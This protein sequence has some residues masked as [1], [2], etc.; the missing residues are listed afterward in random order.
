[1][2]ILSIQPMGT[3]PIDLFA[4]NVATKRP[5]QVDSKQE[6]ENR[7]QATSCALTRKPLENIFKKLGKEGSEMDG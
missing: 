1:M 6:L 4:N 7:E 5:T 2:G 3:L